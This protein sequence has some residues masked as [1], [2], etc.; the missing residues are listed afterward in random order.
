VKQAYYKQL[1]KYHPDV[2]RGNNKE[3]AELMTQQL[4]TEYEKFIKRTKQSK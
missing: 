4:N 1:Q 2:Y 3:F